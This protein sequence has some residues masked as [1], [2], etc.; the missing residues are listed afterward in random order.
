MSNRIKIR[1][2]AMLFA[3]AALTA[4]AQSMGSGSQIRDA[5]PGFADDPGAVISREDIEHAKILREI[6]DPWD[7]SRWLLR[8]DFDHLGGPG[9]LVQVTG[10]IAEAAG[11]KPRTAPPPPVIRAGGRLIITESS[12]IAISRLEA[13]ALEPGAIGSEIKVRLLI[14][15]SVVRATVRGACEAST[16]PQRN[17]RP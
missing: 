8:Q 14:G 9:R 3:A 5:R 16:P 1:V 4:Q 12:K 15:G 17:V 6:K 2:D 7:G 10:E 11:K 13:V